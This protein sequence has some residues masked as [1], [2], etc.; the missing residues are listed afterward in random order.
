MLKIS[1]C[2]CPTVHTVCKVCYVF[3]RSVI[4]KQKLWQKPVEFV[5][6]TKLVN[7]FLPCCFQHFL[8]LRTAQFKLNRTCV[9][10]GLGIIC[11]SFYTHASMHVHARLMTSNLLFKA[12]IC[13][14]TRRVR[15][16][17]Q[18]QACIS[19]MH[20]PNLDNVYAKCKPGTAV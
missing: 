6:Y 1:I 15:D 19:G 10:C 13:A 18:T 17:V 5:L 12:L 4:F 2:S 8:W 16:S 3:V 7:W 11:F 9:R 20:M 14:S